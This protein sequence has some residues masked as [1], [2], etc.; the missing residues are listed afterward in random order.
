LNYLLRATQ[1]G[2]LFAVQLPQKVFICLLVS[3]KMVVEWDMHT[4]ALHSAHNAT[5]WPLQTEHLAILLSQFS[6]DKHT[7]SGAS[8][9]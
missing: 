3:S 8:S 5:A 2:I 9:S 7:L 1:T 4:W 6:R